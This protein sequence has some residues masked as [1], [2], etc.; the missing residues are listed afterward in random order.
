MMKV[1]FRGR[2]LELPE[3]VDDLSVEQYRKLLVMALMLNRGALSLRDFRVAWLSYLLGIKGYLYT[4][5]IEKYR[6]EAERLMPVVSGF[7]TRASDGRDMVRLDS[8]RNLMPVFREWQ[9]PGD[10]LHGMAFD[11]FVHCLHLLSDVGKGDSDAAEEI[12]RELYHVPSSEMPPPEL[13]L[14]SVSMFSSVCEAIMT[15]PIRLNG[16]P[17]DL[18]IIF[19]PSGSR[20]VADDH[21]GWAGVTFEIAAAGVFGTVRDVDKS[22]YLD[23]LLYLYKMKY[24][25]LHDKSNKK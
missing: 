6:C 15:G 5:L 13:V 14:H 8:V 3:H 24:E 11:E 20:R 4:D 17:V 1:V 2:E 7:V 16:E 19:K 10:F 25:Y 18:S 9:G 23:V 12:A 22:P 21:T